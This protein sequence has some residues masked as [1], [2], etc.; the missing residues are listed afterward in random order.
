MWDVLLRAQIFVR[1]WRGNAGDQRHADHQIDTRRLLDHLRDGT[2]CNLFHPPS[3]LVTH[4]APS[5]VAID[6]ATASGGCSRGSG[7]VVSIDDSGKCWLVTCRHNVD[8]NE[9]ITVTAITSAAGRA[10]EVG[11]PYLSEACDV[12]IYPLVGDFNSTPIVLHDAGEVFDDVYTLGFPRVPGA[13]PLM[14]GHRG[15]INGRAHLYLRKCEAIIISNLV[16]PGSSGCPVL[17]KNGR[18]LGMTIRWLEGEWGGEKARFSAA[19]P[20]STLLAE[21]VELRKTKG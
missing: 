20:A 9:G 19:L 18:C 11:D 21:F 15:E 13:Q 17:D 5:V 3:A 12:A 10:L 2:F 4:Y 7:F 6:V 1:Q 14:L 16:S 8:P